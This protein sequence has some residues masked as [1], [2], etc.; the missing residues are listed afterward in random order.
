MDKYAPKGNEKRILDHVTTRLGEMEDYRRNNYEEKWKLADKDFQL[1]PL[2]Q[3]GN[4]IG[5]DFGANKVKLGADDWQSD[6]SSAL[7]FQKIQTAIALLIESNPSLKDMK[8]HRKDFEKASPL[9]K[10]LYDESVS[11]E[12]LK[13]KLKRVIL[14]M[15]RYGLAFGVTYARDERRTVPD[16]RGVDPDTR[17]PRYEDLEVIDFKGVWFE[18]LRNWDVYWDDQ[19]KPYDMLSIE[20]W[21]H[22]VT[23][24]KEKAEGLFGQSKNWQFIEDSFGK[25]TI[26]EHDG[27][28]PASTRN[29]LI[30][31]HVYESVRLDRMIVKLNDVIVYNVPLPLHRI[32]L[33]YGIWNLGDDATLDCVGLPEIMRQ[34]KNLFDKIRNMSI[35][36]LVL[37]IYKMF[38]Y[39]GTLDSEDDDIV[40]S[41]GRGQ[42][43]LDPTKVKWL[44]V[45]SGGAESYKR[46]EMLKSDMDENTGLNKLL[47]GSDLT[48][49]SAYEVEQVKNASMRKL[50]TPLDG[51]RFMLKQD[52]KNR[53]DLIKFLYS[54][55]DVRAIVDPEEVDQYLKTMEE[56][57]EIFKWDHESQTLFMYEYPQ[58]RLK[59]EEKGGQYVP[60]N[61]PRFFYITPEGVNWEGDFEPD[62]EPMLIKLPE[63]EKRS[64]LEFS[65]LVIPLLT[66]DPAI[67]MKPVQQL[68][69]I[70]S[71]DYRD[72]VPASWLD[73]EPTVDRTK[74]TENMPVEGDHPTIKNSK[75][76]ETVVPKT[77]I[78]KP[79]SRLQTIVKKVG[80]LFTKVNP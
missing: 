47:G 27:G 62:I 29:N 60:T 40:I 13:Y 8:P 70:H 48:N 59:L 1:K 22:K 72:W 6:N 44:D 11:K 65:N 75:E 42:A 30:T 7:V 25:E 24:T 2:A 23:Y 26:T 31:G 38:F 43:V 79:S 12:E 10:S 5:K 9:M 4:K 15:A 66:G 20:D 56:N 55:V 77:Q 36:Q 3:K 69:K 35:D 67:N 17:K 64:A 39:D 78:N 52:A 57:P 71:V 68:A 61:E 14:N 58:L 34:D 76:T 16:L 49:K 32:S 53:I 21:A 73:G 45:P 51:L 37:S 80:R 18:P 46:E 50:A 19:A 41:P 74:L 33:T 28:K 54:D 63:L